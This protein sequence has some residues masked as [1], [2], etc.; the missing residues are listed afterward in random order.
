MSKIPTEKMKIA[1]TQMLAS[2]KERK[3]VETVDSSGF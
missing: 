1:I 2:R 3:F